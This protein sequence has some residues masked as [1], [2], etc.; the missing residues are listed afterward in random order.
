MM[1]NEENNKEIDRKSKKIEISRQT[2]VLNWLLMVMIKGEMWID[3]VMK[4]S[5]MVFTVHE[6]PENDHH[7]SFIKNDDLL[8]GFKRLL[9]GNPTLQSETRL[10]LNAY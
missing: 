4:S 9:G 7:D 3:D 5:V 8:P 6:M 1:M 10:L 2:W